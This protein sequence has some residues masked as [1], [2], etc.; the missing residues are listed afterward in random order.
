MFPLWVVP[1]AVGV[2]IVY[3]LLIIATTLDALV[4]PHFFPR[5]PVHSISWPTLGGWV[6]NS[7]AIVMGVVALKR[8]MLPRM[9][10]SGAIDVALADRGIVVSGTGSS[11]C[12]PWR[13]IQSAWNDEH[14]IVVTDLAGGV[15]VIPKHAFPDAG[16][17]WWAWLDERL[18]G[19]RN[20]VRPARPSRLIV[21][22]RN[23]VA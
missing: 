16:A 1:G 23:E 11:R 2:Y 6:V 13:S 15:L 9:P 8:H 21:N 7:L 22:T 19:K 12:V 18:V 20:L 4:A 14:A 17:G 3:S 5:W 10:L